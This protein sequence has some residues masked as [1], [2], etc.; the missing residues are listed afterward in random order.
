MVNGACFGLAHLFLMNWLAVVLSGIGGVVFAYAYH[1]RQ[2]FLLACLLH[3][4]AGQIL[5]T[6]G[7]GI[8]FYHGAVE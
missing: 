2:S 6:T 4:L 8:F 1:L 5:F 7:A 3:V